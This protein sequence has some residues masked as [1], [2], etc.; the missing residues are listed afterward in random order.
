MK[1]RLGASGR[2]VGHITQRRLQALVDSIQRRSGGW[3]SR[4]RRATR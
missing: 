1:P 3:G 4:V 2:L